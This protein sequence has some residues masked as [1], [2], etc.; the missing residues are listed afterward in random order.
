MAKVNGGLLFAKALKNEGVECVFTLC[1]GHIMP[2]FYGLREV[3]IN[4]I[5]FRHECAAAYAADA[6]AQ[7]TGKP[8]VVLT[9]AGPGISDTVTAMLESLHA[10]NPVIHIGGASPV[11][12][13]ETGPLQDMPTMQVLADCTKWARKIYTTARIP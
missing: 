7:V 5:D 1:G 6:Y 12:E 2:I 9:T 8:G 11:S 4:I 3:G 10:G 13:N